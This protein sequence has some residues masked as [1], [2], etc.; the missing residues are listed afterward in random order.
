MFA[1][2]IIWRCLIAINR[3]FKP[4]KQRERYKNEKRINE[5][6][7][8][9]KIRLIGPDKEALGIVSTQDALHRAREYGLDLVEIAP[10]A[11]PPVC[12][13]IDYSKLIFEESKKAREAKKKQHSTQLKEVKF[14]PRTDE[15][16]YN[17]KVKHIKEFLE[18][19]NKVKVTIQFRGRE[20][21]HKELGWELFKRIQKELEECGDFEQQARMEGRFLI[22]FVSP[23]KI[24]S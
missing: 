1:F 5:K 11:N 16:D 13:I 23:K 12:K 17:F 7:T 19:G 4:W 18:K 8:A 20:M 24:Q 3:R 6:I 10:K 22:G 21:A 2:F 9:V 14:R 15:H